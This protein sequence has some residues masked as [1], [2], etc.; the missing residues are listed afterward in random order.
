MQ[1]G[2]EEQRME[3]NTRGGGASVSRS[4]ARICSDRSDLF[5]VESAQ[6]NVRVTKEFVAEGKKR[7]RTSGI[8][9]ELRAES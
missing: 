5:V 9:G 1:R 7:E 4:A 8:E 6:K 3:D 2:V